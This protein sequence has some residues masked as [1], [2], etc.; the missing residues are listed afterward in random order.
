MIRNGHDGLT[1]HPCGFIIHHSKGWLGAS[2]DARVFDPSCKLDGIAEF[3]CPYAT[4]NESPHEACA[5]ADFFCE[6]VNGQIRLKRHHHYYHQVQ[7]QLYV[8][9]DTY[10]FCDF[11]VYTPVD[12]AVERIY[13]CKEWEAKCIPELEDYYDKY[14]LPEILN[15][16]YK[17]SYIL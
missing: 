9:N 8:S 7:L 2:P 1:T 13:P 6:L 16:L 11:C 5:D 15:P 17:P 14:M 3:K 4:R 10:G 12:I